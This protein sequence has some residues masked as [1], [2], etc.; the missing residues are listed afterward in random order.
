MLLKHFLIKYHTK[1]PLLFFFATTSCS[2]QLCLEIQETVCN[3]LAVPEFMCQNFI[4][5]QIFLSVAFMQLVRMAERIDL[6]SF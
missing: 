5:L 3:I 1:I 6:L 2:L 4:A